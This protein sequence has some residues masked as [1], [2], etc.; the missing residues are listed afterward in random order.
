LWWRPQGFLCQYCGLGFSDTILVY[1]NAIHGDVKAV[2]SVE[3]QVF[4]WRRVEAAG[5][6]RFS[7]VN[8]EN[9]GCGHNLV[10]FQV[11]PGWRV[12]VFPGHLEMG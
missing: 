6:D 5:G 9:I 7:G 2:V 10:S 4:Q 8:V 12:T 1:P 3:E 11:L